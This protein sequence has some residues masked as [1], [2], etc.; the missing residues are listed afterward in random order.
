MIFVLLRLLARLV[1]SRL[2][3]VAEN[4]MLRRSWLQRNAGSR[5]NA[6]ASPRRSVGSSDTWRSPRRR[7][8]RLSPWSNRPRSCAG[9]AR[10]FWLGQAGA[11]GKTTLISVIA[12]LLD[13]TGGDSVGLVVLPCLYAVFRDQAR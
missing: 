12:G 2:S 10:A 4:E 5:A 9:T 1:R 3:L 7:G 11:A 6:S 13:R 8:A